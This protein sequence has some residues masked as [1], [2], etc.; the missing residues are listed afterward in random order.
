LNYSRIVPIMRCDGHHLYVIVF[1]G[2]L[3]IIM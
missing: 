3:E 1:S 2:K